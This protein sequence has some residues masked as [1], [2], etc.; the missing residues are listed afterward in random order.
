[1]ID[2][3]GGRKGPPL[4]GPDNPKLAGTGPLEVMAKPG[5]LVVL[6]CEARQRSC[7]ERFQLGDRGGCPGEAFVEGSL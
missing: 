5:D 1:V 7:P 2:Q 4:L 3:P 6:G